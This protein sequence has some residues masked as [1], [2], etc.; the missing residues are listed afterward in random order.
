MDTKLPEKSNM[1]SKHFKRSGQETNEFETIE[2]IDKEQKLNI[3]FEQFMSTIIC[4]FVT[5]NF[6]RQRHAKKRKN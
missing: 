4:D 3:G 2:N 5:L 6:V 1:P